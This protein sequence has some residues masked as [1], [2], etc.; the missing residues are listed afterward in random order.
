M[1]DSTTLDKPTTEESARGEHTG[2]CR[3]YR[4]NVDI[5]ERVDELVVLA[6]VPGVK[7]DA[8]DVKFEDGIL[9]IHAPAEPR[10]DEHRQC[11]LSEYGVGDYRRSFRL[12]EAIDPSKIAADYAD[13]VLTLH[14]PKTEATKPRKIAVQ[15]D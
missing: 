11:L 14:L 2:T 7:A 4:P 15:A 10:R 8:I 6:D 3:C 1:A 13:G 9:S 12:G 5:L